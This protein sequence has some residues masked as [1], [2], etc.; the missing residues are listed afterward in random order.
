MLALL[1]T[2]AALCAQAQDAPPPQPP[3]N[4]IPSPELSDEL[5]L[6]QIV[7]RVRD[8]YA[9]AP[10][11]ERIS[12]RVEGGDARPRQADLLVRASARDGLVA[13]GPRR[14]RLE[15]GPLIVVVDDAS[16]TALHRQDRL[17]FVRAEFLRPPGMGDVFALIPA[18]PLPYATLLASRVE[19]PS[20]DV[21]AWPVPQLDR[22]QWHTMQ[23]VLPGTLVRLTGTES[24]RIVE[25]AVDASTWS[26]SRYTVT[27]GVDRPLRIELAFS[28]AG[29]GE[30]PQDFLLS[31]ESRQ[32]VS[33]IAELRPTEPALGVGAR[34]PGIGLMNTEMK[35]LTLESLLERV[36]TSRGDASIEAP[37][38]ALIFFDPGAE[39]MTPEA[40]AG[41]AAAE[42]LRQR[43]RE[44]VVETQRPA[45]GLAI[46]AV[47]LVEVDRF[48]PSTILGWGER[49]SANVTSPAA[50][51]Q[52]D[53]PPALLLS[54]G[55]RRL[56]HRL[57]PGASAV[58]VLVD[59]DQR[60]L[61]CI[62]LDGRVNDGAAL[63]AELAAALEGP[64]APR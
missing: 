52:R 30:G 64:A 2:L 40:R 61:A 24:G 36:D 57:A 12:V 22:V 45:R 38:A 53:P 8:A 26:L 13:D 16:L 1:P 27:V 55:E 29:P 9:S 63:L 20:R 35:P 41:V 7:E 42:A 11:A 3:P 17:S 34:I 39:G 28:P 32:R 44:R 56:L 60:L 25:A 6:E 51:P 10:I 23:R 46:A 31:T 14:V 58:A 15:L 4:S 19:D 43:L 37:L 50:Q 62:A 5:T 49:W 48:S 18:L 21:S 47:A 54:I 33:S 59:R